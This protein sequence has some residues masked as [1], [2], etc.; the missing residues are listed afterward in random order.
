ML[1]SVSQARSIWISPKDHFMKREITSLRLEAGGLSVEEIRQLVGRDD[2]VILEIGANVGQTTLD[3]L[4]VMPRARIYCFE[5]DPR[6]IAQ[7]KATVKSPNV[8]LIECG[9]GNQ[10]GNVV[11]HQS[12]GTEEYTDWNQSGSIRAP[13]EVTDVWNKLTF[14]KTIQIP[15]VRLDDWAKTQ[16]IDRID[17]IWADVQGAEGDVILG[18]IETLNKSRYFY[19]EYGFQELYEGQI[20]LGEIYDRLKNFS[21]MRVFSMDALFENLS[22]AQGGEAK[23]SLGSTLGTSRLGSKW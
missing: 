13:K 14:E 12:S 16:N 9:V 6:A 22:F 23:W 17:F 1:V 3:F 5:P 2:P 4:R 20:T 18:G 11:F 19:T 21:I 15:I 7:F 8:K 10:N